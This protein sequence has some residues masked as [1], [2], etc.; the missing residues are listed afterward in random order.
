MA[1]FGKRDACPICGG[2]VKGLFTTKVGGQAICKECCGTIHLPEGA[3]DHMSVEGFKEYM[4]FRQENAQLRDEFCVTRKVDFGW[5]DDKFL[6]D[7]EKGL[8]GVDNDLEKTIFQAC[9]IKSFIIKEDTAPLFEGNPSGL[10]AY[11]SNVPERLANM[12]PQLHMIRMKEQARRVSGKD[13]GPRI[14]MNI[15]EPFKK[16]I[17]EIRLDHPY[18]SVFTADMSGPVFSDTYPDP[19]D[20]LRKYQKDVATMEELAYALKELA[21]PNAPE[22]RVI[23]GAAVIVGGAAPAAAAAAAAPVDAVAEI[24]K[25]KALAEQGVITEEEFAAKKRQLLG[26]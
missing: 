15:P 25:Y 6:F 13:E 7:M 5:L 24:Q 16:F 2:K 18:W 17:V 9:H 26:I 20:Y 19:D 8:L 10:Y 3:L 1:L 4:A 22:Q 23:T 14:H 11:P 12:A 21:F